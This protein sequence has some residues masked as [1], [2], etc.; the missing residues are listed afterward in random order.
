MSLFKYALRSTRCKVLDY[1]TAIFNAKYSKGV[2]NM[3]TY[4]SKDAKAHLYGVVKVRIFFIPFYVVLREQDYRDL[5]VAF[6]Y[7]V[8]ALKYATKLKENGSSHGYFD[9]ADI[10]AHEK[11]LELKDKREKKNDA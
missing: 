10:K 3:I 11:M 8:D 1:V 4:G 2:V 6:K 7:R 5:S 9:L